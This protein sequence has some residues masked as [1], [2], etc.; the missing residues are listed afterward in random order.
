MKEISLIII[1]ILIITGIYQLITDLYNI[2]N[3]GKSILKIKESK[4]LSIFWSISLIFWVGMSWVNISDYVDFKEPRGI[5]NIILGVFWI[6]F[7]IS[8][9]IKSIRGTEIREN[10]IY[11][12]GYFYKW[13]KINSYS[14][15]AL[16]TIIFNIKPLIRI[17]RSFEF[18]VKEENKLIVEEILHGKLTL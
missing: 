5:Y 17:N 15:G 8:N 9:I 4:G 16:D 18:I 11:N 14:W 7:S 12:L 6:E 2:F 3:H 10:G 1:I 13:S